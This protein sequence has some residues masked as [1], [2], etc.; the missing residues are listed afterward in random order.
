M[1]KIVQAVNSMVA[2]PD[3]V[4]RVLR[5]FEGE[6][7]FLYKGKY[8]WSI[9]RNDDGEFFLFYYPGD[10][11]LEHLAQLQDYEWQDFGEMVS[12]STKEIGTREARS[13]FS[14]LYT[15]LKERL[16]GVN[17][18]LDDIIGDL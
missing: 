10:Q 7:F 17:E 6:L 14:D 1:S 16:F 2:N 11:T 8:K 12:Y 18:A 9:R 15:L 4:N 13:S 5:G 3:L